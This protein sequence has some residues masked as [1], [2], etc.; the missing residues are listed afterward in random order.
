MAE[1]M[2]SVTTLTFDVVG[3]VID[4]EQGIL[5]WW[6]PRLGGAH[7]GGARR[8]GGARPGRP[9][10]SARAEG[11]AQAPDGENVPAGEEILSAF[12]EAEDRLQNAHP[13]MPFTQMLPRIYEELAGRWGVEQREE[14]AVSFQRSIEEWP[15]FEDSV[16]ALRLLGR[17]F[18]LVA[19]TN[20][21]RWAT[22]A[23]NRTIGEQFHGLV[24]CDEVGV[25]KP[26]H[27]VFAYALE[28]LGASREEVLHVA[29]SQYHDLGGARSFGL[30]TAWVERRAGTGSTGATP[31]SRNV[32]K[33]DIH[34]HSLA[35]LA[36]VLRR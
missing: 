25:N 31:P 35:E 12:A 18:R 7:L 15:P 22:E 26:D 20:A 14:A 19:V 4:F 16:E 17:S 6:L 33:P 34:V 13:E 8:G 27:R 2:R 11:A 36:E 21:D 29:Q 30:K 32:V 5:D 10:D 24:S 3:T 23:M 9:G 28:K 1:D